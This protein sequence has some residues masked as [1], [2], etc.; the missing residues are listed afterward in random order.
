MNIGQAASASGVNAKMIRYYEQIGLVH[1]AERTAANYRSF[2]ER[3]VHELRFIRTARYLGYPVDN[4][5]QLLALWR[6]RDR[7]SEE[8]RAVAAAHVLEL[9]Q[10]AAAMADM[11][12]T[13]RHLAARSEPHERPEHPVLSA[14]RTPPPS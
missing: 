1:P 11:A 2:D 8:V 5:G 12:E 13:L 14:P 10:R 7:P 3:N 9:E 4:I 6:D